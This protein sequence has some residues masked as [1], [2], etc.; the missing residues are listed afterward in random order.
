MLAEVITIGDE[1]LIGQVVD[2]NA[3]YIARELNKIGVATLRITSVLDESKH[4][5][6]ALQGAKGEVQIV[7]LTGGL[8]PTKDDV[9]KQTF[10]DFFSDTL[11]QDENVVAN[12][13]GLFKMYNLNLPLPANLQ[14]AMVPS[15][16]TVL[17]NRHGTAPGMWMEADGVVFI[18]LPGVPYEMKHLMQ[19]EVL[20]R[21]AKKFDRPYIYHKT[22]LTYGLG[23]S[24]VADRIAAWEEALP[25][26]IK[27]GYLPSLGK[28]RLRLSAQGENKREVEEEVNTKM[29]NLRELLSDIA[30][31]Y[32]GETS[33]VERIGKILMAKNNTLSV[34]ESCTGGKIAAEITKHPGVSSWFKGGVIPY[35]TELKTKLLG[36]P[37]AFIDK[38]NVVS[39]EVA[40]AMAEQ[41]C[42][43]LDSDF[44]VATTGIAGPTQGD[45]IDEVG[46]V[47]IAVASPKGVFSEK[48]MFGKDR[49]RVMEKATA[50]AFELLWKEIAKI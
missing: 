6:K 19:E 8:G 11:V 36:V 15:K 47:Y 4:I 33:I 42:R 31:G 50:K 30:V 32:E 22:L 39:I 5:L 25:E 2:T 49:F 24:A 43:V 18:S 23:E 35:K 44:A 3:S 7:I 12:I 28:V 26:N 29:E 48:F 20:P 14:Q 1:I 41:A 34:A 10:C 16:A 38:Y 17:M 37:E 21:I 46:T 45:G 13:K 27:L 9:T 40:E